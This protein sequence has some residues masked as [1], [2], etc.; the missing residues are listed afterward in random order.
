LYRVPG[1]RMMG[2]SISIRGGGDPLIV[3]DDMP[4][5]PVPGETSIDI[6]NMLN[7]N[8]IGQIDILKDPINLAI[9]GSRGGNGVIVIYTKKGEISNS[10][11]SFNLKQ[12]IPLGYQAPIEFYSP[13]YDTPESINNPKPD[14]RTTI[15]WKP[16]VIT[17]D[18]GNA[19]LDFYT[20]DDPATYS[21]II[22]GVA[23]DGKLIHFYGKSVITVK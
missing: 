2:N 5:T 21:V 12:M 9:Y 16:D 7:I 8:D 22:E 23:D 10:L 11:P 19:H 17:D 13:K 15:Y 6:L 18:E 20:A 3:I 4:I 1:V 14:L